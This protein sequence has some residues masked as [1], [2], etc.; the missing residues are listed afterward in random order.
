MLFSMSD[1]KTD[2]DRLEEQA[3]YLAKED[4]RRVKEWSE[5]RERNL[6]IEAILGL[7]GVPNYDAKRLRLATIYRPSN[8]GA[9][10][11]KPHY[12]QQLEQRRLVK[13]MGRLGP[14][15]GAVTGL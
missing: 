7:R 6:K 10:A 2:Q 3:E 9:N 1:Y 11:R 13:S 8:R 5:L 12:R 4:R 14:A 15:R